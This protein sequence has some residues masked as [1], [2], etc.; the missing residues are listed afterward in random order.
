MDEDKTN[1]DKEENW[2]GMRNAKIFFKKQIRDTKRVGRYVE[3]EENP[4]R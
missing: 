2:S 1:T 4:K 3:E